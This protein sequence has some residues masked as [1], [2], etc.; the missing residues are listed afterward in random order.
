MC[1][2]CRATEQ[3]IKLQQKIAVAEEECLNRGFAPHLKMR[4]KH[5][6]PVTPSDKALSEWLKACAAADLYHS[7]FITD[8]VT[9]GVKESPQAAHVHFTPKNKLR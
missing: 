8:Q 2:Q 6:P 3:G 7:K 1:D 5:Q 4:P 9:R